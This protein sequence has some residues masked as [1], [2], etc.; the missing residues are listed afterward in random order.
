MCCKFFEELYECLPASNEKNSNR[1]KYT[2][3]TIRKNL[4]NR[5]VANSL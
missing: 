2:I 1:L 3:K 5:G 4:K